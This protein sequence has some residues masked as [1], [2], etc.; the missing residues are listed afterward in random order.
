MLF[1]EK[2]GL[3]SQVTLTWPKALKYV[4][5][6]AFDGMSIDQLKTLVFNYFHSNLPCVKDFLSRRSTSHGT[7]VTTFVI[8]R[9]PISLRRVN[10]KTASGKGNYFIALILQLMCIARTLGDLKHES[11]ARRY[12]LLLQQ[13]RHSVLFGCWQMV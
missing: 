4:E 13:H 8:D 1:R 12:P 6:V 9:L 10:F 5:F 7:T 2:S 11:L 3:E